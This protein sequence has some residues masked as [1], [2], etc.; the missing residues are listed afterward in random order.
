MKSQ[1]SLGLSDKIPNNVLSKMNSKLNSNLL[2]LFVLV[3]ICGKDLK[4]GAE[5]DDTT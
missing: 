2:S 5:Q 3:F 4:T 1:K